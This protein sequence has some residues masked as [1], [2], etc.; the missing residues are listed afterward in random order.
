[1]VRPLLTLGYLADRKEIDLVSADGREAYD[2]KIGGRGVRDLRNSIFGLATFLVRNPEVKRGFVLTSLVRISAGRVRAEWER[3]G[4]A[5]RPELGGR[6]Q[7]VAVVEGREVVLGAEGKRTPV[8]ERFLE[9]VKAE[10]GA[11]GGSKAGGEGE[12]DTRGGG[13]GGS[14]GVS[15]KHLEVEK[16]LLHRWL[17]DEGAIAVGTL[18]RQVG[19]SYPTAIEA[20]R[21]LSATEGLIARGRARSV[22]LARY[23]RDRWTE[24]LRA[25][26]LVYP[27][28]EFVS[29]VAEPGAV[30]GILRRL[31][32]TKPK[33]A[34]LGGVVA[35][36]RWDPLFDLNGTPRIDVVL[37]APMTRARTGGGGGW[38]KQASEF[39]RRIDP[40]LQRRG[41]A[42]GSSSSQVRG[43]TVLVLHRTYRREALFLEEAGAP[44]PWADPVEVICH[45]N[46]MGLTAQAGELVRRL[47]GEGKSS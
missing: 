26:R 24:L 19:C 20:V 22:A 6:M 47:R 17:L 7:L 12:R 32:R 31:Q 5:L 42:T 27:A 44:M 35:A 41:A 29:P 37:H 14:L 3:V 1:M 18:A 34:A 15:W 4:Q 2:I 39:A 38:A 9:W 36:R 11:G 8:V 43:A 33:D 16:V 23:P 30:D 46:E 10:A 45:L 28:A 21:R 25:Q 40:A 13:G